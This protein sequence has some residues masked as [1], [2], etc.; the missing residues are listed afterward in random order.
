MKTRYGVSPWI[1]SIP[2]SRRPSHPR[3][4][5]EQSAD[6]VIVGGGLTGCATAF[7]LAQSGMRVV[8]VEAGRIGQA[9]TGHSPGLL[10]PEPGPAFRDVQERYGLRAARSIFDSWRRGSLDAA[11]LLRRAGIRCGLQPA[12]A[13][14][15]ADGDAEGVLSRDYHARAAAGLD[16]SWL[17]SSRMHRSARIDASGIRMPGAFVLDPYRACLGLASAAAKRGVG[18][19]ERSSVKKLRSLARAVEVVLDGGV[20]RAAVAIVATGAAGPEIKPLRRHFRPR[21]RYAV[22]TEP[23]S[24]AVRRQMMPAGTVLRD[25]R[26]PGRWTRWTSDHR[27][28]VAGADQDAQ[29]GRARAAAL[30]QRTG[31]LMYETLMQYPIITGLRPEY[32]WDVPY[33]DTADGLMYIGAHRHYPR[34]LFALGGGDSLTG[35]FLAARILAR[36]A[37]GEPRKGD[38]LFGWAR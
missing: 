13:L 34:H 29:P 8:L 12:E 4:R 26:T 9:G 17:P 24:A 38:D 20:V 14:R 7:A 27:M 1:E 6:L 16:V 10:M 23:V 31:Q 5:G 22:M 30:P 3:L 36:A 28:L 19:F 21:A 2:V 33:G 35:S 11:A 25:E 15:Y 37:A 32:G 18:V